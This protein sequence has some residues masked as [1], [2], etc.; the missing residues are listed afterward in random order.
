MIEKNRETVEEKD[1]K[2]SILIVDD[3]ESIL[4]SLALILEKKGYETETA[5]T[6]REAMEKVS[7]RF[8]NLAFLDIRL[9]D[10][11]GVE[12]LAPFKEMHPDM[13]VIIVTGYASLETAVLALNEG[14]AAYIT[15]PLNMD[16]VLVKV[17]EGLETQRLAMEN[18]RLYQEAQRELAERKRA[19]EELKQSEERYRTLVEDI[20]DGYFVIQDG[21][22]VYFNQAFANLLEDKNEVIL[23]REFLRH[24]SLKYP[25]RPSKDDRKGKEDQG[26]GGQNEFE[27]L[28]KDG[29]DLILE[30]RWNLI[31]YNRRSAFAGICKDITEKKKAEMALQE[32]VN[33][34]EKWYRLTVDR[35]LKM[36]EL[37]RR[38][39]ELKSRRKLVR[40]NQNI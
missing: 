21:R 22:F 5:V 7:E 25:E 6:G 15:K 33:E 1:E 8:F 23:V 26:H 19:E 37:K 27:I 38:I 9:S 2:E 24:F 20:N 13:V 18:E 39:R 4:R 12:L 32:K 28:G 29:G 10:M 34:L 17:R 35:E 16:E 30:I 14:A 3:D 40:K 36:T 31:D 11:E